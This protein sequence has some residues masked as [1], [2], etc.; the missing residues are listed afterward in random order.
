ML[1]GKEA[2][3]VVY[4]VPS[5]TTPAVLALIWLTRLA[6]AVVQLLLLVS[7]YLAYTSALITSPGITLSDRAMP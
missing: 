5:I 4:C 7:M 2:V 1:A 3:L 6:N